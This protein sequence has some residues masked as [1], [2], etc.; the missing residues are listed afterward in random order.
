M[1]TKT[2]VVGI[3]K[4]KKHGGR[5]VSQKILGKGIEK[6]QSDPSGSQRQS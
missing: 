2:Y 3:I 4:K 6:I 5:V 1:E